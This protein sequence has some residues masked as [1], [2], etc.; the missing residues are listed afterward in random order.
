[1]PDRSNST[2]G[3]A[4]GEA[5]G[6]GELTIAISTEPSTLDGQVVNDRNARVITGNLFESLIRR[7]RKAQLVPGLATEWKNLDESTW[8]FT[9]REGGT[10]HDGSPFNAESAADSINRMV[11]PNFETQRGSY[12]EG[13]TGAE[14]TGEYTLVV[15]TDG[16]DAILPLQ[17]AQVPMV[18][19][20]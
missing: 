13:I 12:I 9:L 2:E 16:P 8:E 4:D 6:G 19:L 3:T 14:A 1:Q 15:K 18:P 20:D 7:D 10:Y 17:M 5:T 11:D